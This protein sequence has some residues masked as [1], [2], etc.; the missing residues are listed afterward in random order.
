MTPNKEDY[1]KCIYELG[2]LDQKITNK[3]IAEKM[4]FS[5]PAVSAMLKKML[6]ENLIYKDAKTGYLLSQTALK[7]VANLYRKHRL[8]EVFLVKQLGY[9]SEEVHEEAEILEHTVSDRFINRL[10]L[11]LEQPQ[12]CPHG[13]TIP[14][15]GQPLIERYQKRLSQLVEAGNYQLVRIHDFYQLLQYLES[16]D[17]RVGDQLTVAGFD[18]FAQTITI[19]YK[20]KELAVPIAI[21]Q[22]LFVEKTNDSHPANENHP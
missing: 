20:N 17:L 2:Q 18:Q 16:H 19:Q 10:D 12:T 4:A 15:E 22:Q 14:Q 9:S 11:L 8:I 5:A 7:M 13:G 6:A 1:L 21:A 3:L